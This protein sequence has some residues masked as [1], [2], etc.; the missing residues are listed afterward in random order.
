MTEEKSQLELTVQQRAELTEL[1]GILGE[2]NVLE[3]R[4]DIFETMAANIKMYLSLTSLTKEMYL[5]SLVKVVTENLDRDIR[6]FSV[7]HPHREKALTLIRTFEI[8]GF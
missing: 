3:S 7:D 1:K 4:K 8:K 5:P 6:E 2:Y